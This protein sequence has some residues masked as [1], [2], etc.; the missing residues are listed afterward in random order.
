MG[1]EYDI[2]FKVGRY[3][4]GKILEEGCPFTWFI[5]YWNYNDSFKIIWRI[6]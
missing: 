5:G 1:S 2:I 4:L 6:I 3:F